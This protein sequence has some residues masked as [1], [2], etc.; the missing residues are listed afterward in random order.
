[1][2]KRAKLLIRVIWVCL[3]TC[4][5]TGN[6]LLASAE[7]PGENKALKAM[8]GELEQKIQDADKSRVAHPTFLQELQTL[9]E[10]YRA[11]LRE[12]FFFDTFSDGDYTKSPEWTVKKGSFTID[13]A[14][15]LTTNV[16]MAAAPA[17]K[18]AQPAKGTTI[19][20]EAVGILLDSI[21]GPPKKEKK[22]AAKPAAPE[23]A[24]I[25]PAYIYMTK[26]FAPAFELNIQFS[27]DASGGE[28]VFELLGGKTLSPRYRLVLKPDHSREKPVEIV[29]ESHSRQFVV[30]A[31]TKF[32][33]INDGKPH[34][35]EWIRYTDGAMHVLIDGERILE[36]YEV[37]YRDSFTGL[38]IGNNGGTYYFD[39]VKIFKALPPES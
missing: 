2:D 36:T 38:G 23:P 31:A 34:T 8:I 35:L 9:V 17:A 29:R 28:L 18:T 32:P 10:K 22:P 4:L 21:F 5:L 39:A 16:A 11:Q 37:Y 13:A 14:A 24:Q 20:Q 1:M 25:K 26:G 33:V 15:R 27:T 30:G 19:E 7:E 3:M 6:G 12:L